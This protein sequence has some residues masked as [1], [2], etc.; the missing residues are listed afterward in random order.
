M[1]E[2]A[3]VSISLSVSIAAV[4]LGSIALLIATVALA[5]IIGLKNSTHQVV[6]KPMEP[7][8]MEDPFAKEEVEFPDLSELVGQQ[9]PNKKFNNEIPVE[10]EPFNDPTDVFET[11]N[12]F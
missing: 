6:W 7:K 2:P 1:I 12:K 4:A 5:L 10:E 8:E 11:S 9:N 3:G